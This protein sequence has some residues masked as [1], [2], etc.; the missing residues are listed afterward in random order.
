MLSKEALTNVFIRKTK[1]KYCFVGDAYVIEAWNGFQALSCFL[2]KAYKGELIL[3]EE[4]QH[5][6]YYNAGIR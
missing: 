1:Y 2:Q 3:D 6:V 5:F 4:R